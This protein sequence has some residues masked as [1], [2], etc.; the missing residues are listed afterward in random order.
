LGDELAASNVN[1]S[2]SLAATSIAIFT[3]MLFFLYPRFKNGEINAVLFQVT[4]IVMGVAT[5]SFV[6]ASLYYYASSLGG[7]IDD[8]ERALYARRGDRFWLLGYSLL[9]LDP[10]VILFSI[11][12]LVVG[13]AWLALWLVY[14]L[15]VI[16]YFPRVQ[17]ARRS[18]SRG[19][20]RA[21]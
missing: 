4:L 15:F 14:V 9:F 12:L 21:G 19:E 1:R 7:R 18:S 10:S 8:V 13:S 5:F 17:T 2:Y 20:V 3:F 6:F 16:R 11:G